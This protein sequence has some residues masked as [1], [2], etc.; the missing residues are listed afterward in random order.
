MV[1]QKRELIRFLNAGK[2]A[3]INYAVL[4]NSTT[5]LTV[6]FLN[7]DDAANVGG[8]AVVR[9]WCNSTTLT[10]T[11]SGLTAVTFNKVVEGNGILTMCCDICE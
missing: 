7:S 8:R 3:A 2:S 6:V 10:P 5:S 9:K 11:P 4:N 1:H